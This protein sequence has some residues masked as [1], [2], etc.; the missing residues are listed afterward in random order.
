MLVSLDTFDDTHLELAFFED[1]DMLLVSRELRLFLLTI[2]DDTSEWDDFKLF[3]VNWDEVA[4]VFWSDD[5]REE[6]L[7]DGCFDAESAFVVSLCWNT[8]VGK[9][10]RALATLMVAVLVDAKEL[11]FSFL[12]LETKDDVSSDDESLLS[13]LFFDLFGCLAYFVIIFRILKFATRM[14]QIERKV[15][16]NQTQLNY[17]LCVRLTQ[18]QS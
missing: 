11:L 2:E 6:L 18:K 16:H 13:L 9:L 3:E 14:R 5:V 4:A 1:W 7:W 8:A 10:L 15:P 17:K 12:S